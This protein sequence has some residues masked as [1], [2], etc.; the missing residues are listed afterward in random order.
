MG[1]AGH[2]G[3]PLPQEL[4]YALMCRVF[5]VLP[6][7]LMQEEADVMLRTWQVLALYDKWATPGAQKGE[8]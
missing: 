6:S 4:L 3:A 2:T 1:D 5:G 7:Q 8:G